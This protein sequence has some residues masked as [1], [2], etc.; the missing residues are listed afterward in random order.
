MEDVSGALHGACTRD[1]AVAALGEH[2]MRAALRAGLLCRLWR[3]VFVPVDRLLDPR[4]RAAAALLLVGEEAVLSG[5]TAAYLLGCDAAV[6]CK[7]V[8][9][10]VPYSRR[11]HKRPGI[12][13]HN[14]RFSAEDVVELAGLRVLALDLVIAELLCTGP[15]W[16][17]VACADQALAGC[18][19]GQRSDFCDAVRERLRQ[20][21]NPKGVRGAHALVALVT[22]KA[23]SPPESWLRLIVVDAG[24]P[25]PVPQFELCDLDGQVVYRLDLAWPTLRIALEYDGYEAHEDRVEHDA[26]RD[27][28]LV[29][30]GWLTV[31]ATAADLA[32]PY[33]LLSELRKAFRAR[34]V[35]V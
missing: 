7:D 35:H 10:T 8:H 9:L 17:A 28:R 33:R 23:E 32:S 3:G 13:S 24:F 1:Q 5:L 22:A 4:T 19:L 18:A 34:G 21:D 15:R 11:V 2:G 29:G 30:R 25:V 31:R 16:S 6:S 27:R 12:V 14:D 20:R 26:E